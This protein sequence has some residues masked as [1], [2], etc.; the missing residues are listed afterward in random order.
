MRTN[1]LHGLIDSDL[2]VDGHHREQ[3]GV[4]TDGGLQQLDTHTQFFIET[5]TCASCL[6]SLCM[7]TLCLPPGP[8]VRSTGLAGR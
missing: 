5:M 4:G 2:V 7:F 3:R 8:P 1:L 6:Y